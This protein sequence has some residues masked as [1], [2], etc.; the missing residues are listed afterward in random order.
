MSLLIVQFWVLLGNIASGKV[1]KREEEKGRGMGEGGEGREER[2]GRE[3]GERGER[4][5]PF[6]IFV[7]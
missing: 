6:L 5:Y 7:N 3:G 4:R 2:E 1:R